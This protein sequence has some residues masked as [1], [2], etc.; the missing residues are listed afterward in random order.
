MEDRLAD[1]NN[2][3]VELMRDVSGEIAMQEENQKVYLC[4]H[5]YCVHVQS[6]R[7]QFVVTFITDRSSL[8]IML[9]HRFGRSTIFRMST[10][11]VLPT[12][13]LT[14]TIVHF[15]TSEYLCR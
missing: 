14:S 12:S 4:S 10:S 5:E 7:Q 3:P 11:I 1:L 6:A 8:Q 15:L 9:S 2:M 13:W